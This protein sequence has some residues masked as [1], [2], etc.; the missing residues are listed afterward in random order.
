MS[1]NGWVGLKVRG[2]G[3]R[4]AVPGASAWRDLPRIALVPE[5]AVCLLPGARIL[6]EAP[7]RTGR[8][9]HTR[10]CADRLSG[11]STAV[12]GAAQKV[13]YYPEE[14]CRPAGDGG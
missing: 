11:R 5:R 10:S 3:A 7:E 1:G 4:D 9:R 14:A 12:W 13:V 2:R 6:R 8:S